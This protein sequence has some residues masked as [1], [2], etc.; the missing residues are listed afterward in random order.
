[1]ITIKIVFVIILTI[2]S[3]LFAGLTIGLMSLDLFD[4]KQKAKDDASRGLQ[5][6]TSPVNL[7]ERLYNEAKTKQETNEERKK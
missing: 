1:M 5:M 2:V 3:G 6:S 7:V 4:L